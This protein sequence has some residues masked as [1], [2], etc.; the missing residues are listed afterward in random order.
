MKLNRD[1]RGLFQACLTGLRM[2]LVVGSGVGVWGMA[3]G[4]MGAGAQT[5]PTLA[6]VTPANGATGV[7]V[8]SSL[9]FVF[10]QAMAETPAIPSIPG[11]FVGNLEITPASVPMLEC[12]W[13]TDARTLTCT[14]I[15]PLPPNTTVNWRINPSGA[16]LRFTSAA[17][18]PVATVTGSFTTGAGSGGGGGDEPALVAASPANGA[19]GVPVTSNVRFVFDRP[20]EKTPGIGGLS[21][22]VGAV[23]WSGMDV[24]PLKFTYSW[25]EDGTTLTAEYAGDL[26]VNTAISWVLNPEGG[27]VRLRS[28]QGVELPEEAHAGGFLTGSGGGGGGGEECELGEVPEGWGFFSVGKTLLYRQNSDAEPVPASENAFTFV[29]S[30]K[31]PDAEALPSEA[32][33]TVPPNNTQAMTITPFFGYAM[34][35]DEEATAQALN[36][37]YPGGG[38][39]LR[40]QQP[41]QQQR[42]F[43]MT[44]PAGAP[45]V[46]R[47]LNH[48]EAQSVNAAQAF[49]LRWNPF[50]GVNAQED[51]VAISITL[52]GEVVFDAPDLCVPRELSPTA[53]SI[54]I[55]ANTLQANRTYQVSLTFSDVFYQSTNAAPSMSG[56]GAVTVSTEFSLKTGTGGGPGPADPARFTSYRMLENGRPQM[57]L[58]GTAGRGYTIQRATRL[59][60]GDW[61][62]AGTVEMSAGGTATFEDAQAGVAVGQPRFY[63]AVAN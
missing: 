42:S 17:G 39:T 50:T 40:Y 28:V 43:S 24:D 51:W 55:P 49:T 23:A 26:P 10:N 53:T 6:S 46:P 37:A 34:Y 16:L 15:D 52:D 14:G 3:G 8:G 18:I 30:L 56:H 45:P 19:F 47:V 60:P 44:M 48:A 22:Q 29:A 35:S 12:E 36:A 9:V 41:G 1:S 27:V 20:M 13:G 38:Y 32:S 58:T 61:Q 25:N 21:G 62:A 7:E 54:V 4:G 57:T 63:R 2:A 59:G 11:A 33:V 5:A 31:T